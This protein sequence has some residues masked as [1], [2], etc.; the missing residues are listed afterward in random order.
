VPWKILW[1][2]DQIVENTTVDGRIISGKL[3]H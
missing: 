1:S 2:T 3:A